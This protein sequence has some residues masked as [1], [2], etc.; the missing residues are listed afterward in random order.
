MCGIVGVFNRDG[1]PVD[2]GMLT[3]MR[4]VLGHRGPDGYGNYLSPPGVTP[5]VGLGH[6]RLAII[7]LTEGGAQPMRSADGRYH[8]VYNGEIYN[9]L[10]LKDELKG[11]G[12]TFS[13]RS[14]TEVILT[15]YREWGE[16]VVHRL[17]GMFSLA[18]WDEGEKRLFLARDPYGIKPLIYR[19]DGQSFL[20][21]SEIKGIIASGVADGGLDETA[22]MYYLS[23]NYIPAPLTIYTDIKKLPP[24]HAIR[25]DTGG[26]TVYR[27]YDLK[28]RVAGMDALSY[29]D[30]TA[31]LRERVERAVRRRL[32]SDVPLG[33]FLSGG[34]DSS[35]ITCVMDGMGV[36]TRTFS[37]G[38]SDQQRFDETG[39]AKA[40]IERGAHIEPTIHRIGAD[41]LF[42][43]IPRVLD[44]L[45]EP[46]GDSSVIPTFMVSK[47]TR[48]RV[49]VA[50]S[51]DGADEVFGGYWKYLGEVFMGLYRLIPGRRVVIPPLLSRLPASKG[52]GIGEAVRKMR[53]FVSGDHDDPAVRHYRWLTNFSQAR[54]EEYLSSDL[55]DRFGLDDPAARKVEHLYEAFQSDRKNRMFYCD[56]NLTLPD[57]MLVKVDLMSMQNSLEVRVPF[58]DTEVVELAFSLAGSYKLSGTT[59]KRILQDAFRDILPPMIVGRPKQGF[60][61]PIGEWFKGRLGPMFHDVVTRKGVDDLGVFRYDAVKRLLER[62]TDGRADATFTLWNIFLLQW[63][64]ANH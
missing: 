62:H 53:K 55:I 28:E 22:L 27:Y 31:A 13:S 3:R 11:L 60:E 34:L 61:M 24:G 57:D 17:V 41:D 59:R 10:E 32:I 58:L 40:V 8:I 25:V 54:G 6:R 5:S 45:D 19:W 21:S 2:K 37:I 64:A 42:D 23:L 63:W 18:V 39:Y 44:S 16:A 49:T 30:A 36:Q 47:K 51:G 1:A 33:A 15:G 38:F 43:L 29:D 7:D 46:F 48:E 20:F 4:D 9:F 50:L 12:Y 14:D 35:I 56:F 52:S 26:M